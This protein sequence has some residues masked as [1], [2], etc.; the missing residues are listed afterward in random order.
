MPPIRRL[1]MADAVL[2]REKNTVPW[3]ISRVDKFKQT[4]FVM[5]RSYYVVTKVFSAPNNGYELVNIW[6]DE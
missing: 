6:W 5:H 3:L 1:T 4:C 2:L